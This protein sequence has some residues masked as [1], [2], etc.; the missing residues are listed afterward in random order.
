MKSVLEATAPEPTQY[1][2]LLTEPWNAGHGGPMG[3]ILGT[4]DPQGMSQAQRTHKEHPR[5]RGPTRNVPG[6][7]T[8]GEHRRHKDP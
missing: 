3:S 7:R 6:T 8:H 1:L 5:H 4:K 2:A